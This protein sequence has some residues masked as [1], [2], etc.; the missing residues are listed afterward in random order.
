VDR[1]ED[2][3]V[4]DALRGDRGDAELGVAALGFE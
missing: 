3:G 4:V 1:V 2:L